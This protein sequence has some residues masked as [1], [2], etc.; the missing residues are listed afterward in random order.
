MFS[1]I[2]KYIS[3]RKKKK[4][5]KLYRS[6]FGWAMVRYYCEG[7]PIEEIESW[8]HLSKQFCNYNE[9]DVGR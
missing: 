8:V 3:E 7:L 9:F 4:E 6:G 2:K 5:T 1:I